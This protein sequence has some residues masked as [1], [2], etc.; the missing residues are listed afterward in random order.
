MN[1]GPWD[2]NTW[3]PTSVLNNQ[4]ARHAL[5]DSGGQR[6]QILPAG[7]VRPLASKPKAPDGGD[8]RPCRVIATRRAGGTSPEVA[9]GR[10]AEELDQRPAVADCLPGPI[11]I[12]AQVVSAGG[13]R[14]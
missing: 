9:G 13:L 12:R 11:E 3:G 1:D 10:R 6:I 8:A 4:I 5:P 7:V 14:A 2:E